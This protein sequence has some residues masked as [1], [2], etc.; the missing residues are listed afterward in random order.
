M[1][2]TCS[3]V[4]ET[5]N[6]FLEPL[7]RRAVATGTR[8]FLRRFHLLVLLLLLI[9][10]YE[11]TIV[12]DSRAEGLA[13]M[14]VAPSP[15]IDSDPLIAITPQGHAV[16]AWKRYVADPESA[17][18]YVASS[19]SWKAASIASLSP[20]QFRQFPLSLAAAERVHLAWSYPTTDTIGIYHYALGSSQFQAPWEQPFGYR[21]AF[22]VDSD[23]IVHS[24]W[25]EE[26]RIRY[27]TNTQEVS[28]TLAIE[29]GTIVGELLLAL[30]GN[31]VAHLAWSGST[32]PGQG[33]QI[34]YAPVI[35]GT[36]PMLVARGHSPQ[37][38]VSGSGRVH[39]AWLRDGSLYYASSADW[40]AVYH[41][42][43]DL[44]RD[45]TAV[46]IPLVFALAVAPDETAHLVWT[47]DDTLWHATSLDWAISTTP[48]FASVRSS[49][50]GMA[51][52][53][54]GCAHVVWV[55]SVD[56]GDNHIYY[57][58]P[59]EAAPQL[60]LTHPV[61]QEILTHDVALRV[62]SNLDAGELLRVEFYLQAEEAVQAQGDAALVSLGLDRDG[63][64]GW[65]MP[66]HIADLE[67]NKRYRVM[68]L[69]TLLNGQ[70]VRDVGS[71]FR[72]QPQ[73]ADS[74]WLRANGDEPVRGR[75]TL[76]YLLPLHTPLQQVDFF[77]TPVQCE[78][79]GHLCDRVHF[80][81]AHFHHL[82]GQ[83]IPQ[84][85]RPPATQWQ[86]LAYES[87]Q[88][89]DGQYVV[90][91]L[92]TDRQG[93]TSYGI[94]T[95]HFLIDNAMFPMV[96]VTSP[97]EGALVTDTLTV[98]AQA[99]DPNGTIRRVD[100]YL[101]REQVQASLAHQGG[102]PY[103]SSWLGGDDDGS[104]GW[105]VHVLTHGF[106]HGGGWYIRAVAVDDTGLC[107]SVRSAGTFAILGHDSPLVRLVR[108]SGQEVLNSVE[109]ITL[110]V[111]QGSEYLSEAIV[112][113]EDLGG[114]LTY[115]GRMAASEGH[116]TYDWDTRDFPN[117]SYSLLVIGRHQD[118][119]RSL[120]RSGM[121]RIENGNPSCAIKSP[122][123]GEMLH[124]ATLI[125]LRDTHALPVESVRFCY[126][127]KGGR[128]YLIDQDD[129]GDNGW[130]TV[131]NTAT[132]LD[133]EYQLV[134]LVTDNKGQISRFKRQ[135]IVRNN[136]PSIALKDFAAS[137]PWH[138]FRR[139]SWYAE[140][141]A[142]EPMTVTVEYSPD[143][144]KHWI[145]LATDIPSSET[146]L[147]DT[148][149]HPDATDARLRLTVT[150]GVRYGQTV[151]EPF[152]VDNVNDPPQ[153]T[154]LSP[155]AGKPYGGPIRITWQAWDP[156]DDPLTVSL[157]YRRDDGDWWPLVYDTPDRGYYDWD[158]AFSPR[159]E[160][161][162]LRVTVSDPSLA[163]ATDVV[164]EITYVPNTPPTV[165]LLWPNNG[166]HLRDKTLIL[167][168]ASD[169]DDDSV[170]ID[171]Y[172]SDNAGR[173]W[174][175][176]A[177]GLPNT[178]YY[179]WQMSYLPPGL[180]YRMRVVARDGLFQS[181]D[182]NEGAI[183]VG[184]S[185]L[186]QVTLLSPVPGSDVSD[187]Q[188]IRWATFD[189]G[190]SF[191]RA[192]VAVRRKGTSHWQSLV[193]DVSNDGFYLWDTKRQ[194]DGKYDLRVTVTD[195]QKTSSVISREPFSISNRANHRPQVELLSPQGGEHWSGL[196]EIR[197]RAW[198]RDVERITATLSI[199]TDIG[200]SWQ[201]IGC[202]DARTGF[203]VWDT[204]LARRAPGYL[205]QI[206]VTDGRLSSTDT[207]AGV[208]YLTNQDHP[209]H[210]LITSPDSSGRL[211]PSH[212]VTWIAEDTDGD[213]L[214][215]S[216]FL[217]EQ[218]GTDWRRLA[219]GLY[220]MGEYVLD[221]PLDPTRAY[222]LR[223][224]ASDGVYRTMATTSPLSFV[225]PGGQSPELRFEF[226]VEG[227]R[228]TGTETIR[229][230][231]RATMGAKLHLELSRDL[232]QTWEGLA[233]DLGDEGEWDWD[234]TLVPNGTFV[235][236]LI[237]VGERH[238]QVEAS[239]PFT[240]ENK[241][242]NAPLIS[243][244]SPRGGEVWFGAQEVLWH[245]S[246]PDRDPLR[247]DLSYSLDRG[248]TWDVIARFLPNSGSYTWDTTSVPNCREVWL[249][250]KVSDGDF[251]SFALSAGPI[252]VCN[253]LGPLI[254]LLAP[255]HGAQ[256]TGRQDITWRTSQRMGKP[257]HVTI[258]TSLDMGH[259]WR[260]LASDLPP[261]GSYSWDTASLPKDS[262]VLIR[263]RASDGLQ[264]AV[265]TLWEPIIV[266]GNTV[267][268]ELPFYVR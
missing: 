222:Q 144:G 36:V 242:R 267:S 74:L 263:V 86:S 65:G 108:P 56:D 239:A 102:E 139:V 64:D 26:D 52:D 35:S 238:R 219:G 6:L 204:R 133:G 212:L 265:D 245:S 253:R 228:L 257:A 135:V 112:Y 48:L 188:L 1:R 105:G 43:G 47:K 63:R 217:R 207:S 55:G 177:E 202:L 34:Y 130:G 94:P 197:W 227:A 66:L 182:D 201:R 152:S 249:R 122:R 116:W 42:A 246:D 33:P 244:V 15:A 203:Y 99:S 85:M 96:E 148:E 251:E 184:E 119:A 5:G 208:F 100:F 206:T 98:M 103:D 84:R 261:S 79:D 252:S 50:L 171:L 183:I 3:L 62:E 7:S 236:R 113:V 11:L 109:R 157:D 115:V 90:A 241:G 259:I 78:L 73:Q 186:P 143:D 147:W 165:N 23:G 200:E 31:G 167:W 114:I 237:A 231:A 70:I 218:G 132:A 97:K 264:A 41:V 196:E 125:E 185:C 205:M 68:V 14:S 2:D 166:A 123:V 129:L 162:D 213:P 234:T 268:Q 89:A 158:P 243:L 233:R 214:S 69:G 192:A 187:L 138:G 176:L 224:L 20:T 4:S 72:V 19:P 172:Y 44:A 16:I 54:R 118:G 160:T 61:G 17:Q 210:L 81:T 168:Q 193:T 248:G 190:R 124:G 232:G 120:V 49:Q 87:R 18:L 121:L 134:V 53:G 45:D 32:I 24:A 145:Q 179:R 149:A 260:V 191:L 170:L 75:A 209:P 189:P 240:I 180:E 255:Q 194:N 46:P 229:W 136:T 25:S 266:R 153:V 71:W 51:V 111:D 39:L 37:L 38:Q 76:D 164:Q 161:Y 21:G 127:D 216:V 254:E 151:S 40:S 101:E 154:L 223:L 126:Q 225:V 140:H 215:I 173:A 95:R 88:L 12:R 150:D 159:A 199:S 83:D 230:R 226:P 93:Q 169:E 156:D 60:R 67:Y 141:P 22:V 77:F 13:P 247:I 198:D 92:A 104:D 29:P 221:A 163:I 57:L 8:V 178:G 107:S 250:A 211:L 91:A 131:W 195:G 220:N 82:A 174:F 256:W 117:G 30:D 110:A 137:E 155:Q 128:L 9:S 106:W 181:W 142:G 27:A 10:F 258:E 59:R 235:L 262:R 80:S 58:P 146:F 175:P 28:V